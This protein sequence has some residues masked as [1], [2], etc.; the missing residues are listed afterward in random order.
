MSS[1][2]ENP[3]NL[4]LINDVMHEHEAIDA[5]IKSLRNSNHDL[6]D[7]FELVQKSDWTPD[8][9]NLLL[10]KLSN[11]KDRLSDL[12]EGFKNHFKMDEAAFLPMM[13]D[14]MVR[15]IRIEHQNMLKELDV[16]RQ[17]QNGI[18]AQTV[19]E[20]GPVIISKTDSLIQSIET[21]VRRETDMLQLI[22]RVFKTEA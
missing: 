4:S 11:L 18:T 3:N 13:G 10:D 16:I 2:A 7:A 1:E 14:L 12:E 19:K 6:A 21:H 9:I 5:S 15:A 8:N 17:L 22:S 20:I